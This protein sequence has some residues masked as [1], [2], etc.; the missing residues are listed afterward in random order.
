MPSSRTRI[1]EKIE[2]VEKIMGAKDIKS[3][4]QPALRKGG[5]ELAV[6]LQMSAEKLGLKKP[7]VG[8]EG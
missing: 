5:E 1:S 4:D 3:L 2:D 8:K 6:M 7:T